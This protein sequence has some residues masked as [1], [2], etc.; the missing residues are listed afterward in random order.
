MA[1]EKSYKTV[2]VTG[3]NLAMIYH[4]MGNK[5][6][7]LEEAY[8]QLEKELGETQAPPPSPQSSL[9]GEPLS[10]GELEE[11]SEE[12]EEEGEAPPPI[13]AKKRQRKNP[14]KAPAAKAP[15]K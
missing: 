10:E 3:K 11:I 1:S 7:S 13:P 14:S 8:K 12:E 5:T 4:H 15:S 9:D 2:P 6:Q